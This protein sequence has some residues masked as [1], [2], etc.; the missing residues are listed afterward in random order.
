MKS[1]KWL[2]ITDQRVLLST[3][4]LFF[5]L[6]IIF[7][8]IHELFRPGF[9]EQ[10]LSTTVSEVM[11]LVGGVMIE[12]PILMV[13]LSRILTHRF[14]RWANIGAGLLTLAIMAV[15]FTTPDLDNIFFSI[16]KAATLGW[17]VWR[18]WRWESPATVVQA[19][20]L[21]PQGEYA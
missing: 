16:I 1:E 13:L 6:N 2:D 7:Q 10:M 8:D 5:L 9:M 3:L 15:T 19:T 4:W 11:F 17:I 20:P 14:N 21:I 12:I 18:A